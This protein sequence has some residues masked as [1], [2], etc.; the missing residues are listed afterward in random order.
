MADNRENIEIRLI[1][2]ADLKGFQ[3]TTR[4]LGAVDRATEQSIAKQKQLQQEIARTARELRTSL[5]NPSVNPSSTLAS[6][7]VPTRQSSAELRR[8]EREA[9]LRTERSMALEDAELTRR[10]NQ[11]NQFF[12]DAQR[13]RSATQ[14][15]IDAGQL[16]GMEPLSKLQLL[17]AAGTVAGTAAKGFSE[18]AKQQQATQGLAAAMAQHGVLSD[19]F[20]TRLQKLAETQREGTGTKKAQWLEALSDL[21]ASGGDASNID[22]LTKGV[23]DLAGIMN[24]NIPHA[25]L[26][27][28]KAMQGNFDTL[29]EWGIIVPEAATQ[30]QKLDSALQQMAEKGAN[31]LRARAESL[32]GQWTT[33]KESTN[34]LLAAFAGTFANSELL[35]G[36]LSGLSTIIQKAA[37]WIGRTDPPLAQMNVRLLASSRALTDAQ[38][39]AAAASREFNSIASTADRAAQALNR[40]R[41]AADS[42]RSAQDQLGDAE[43]QLQ[44]AQI[45]AAEHSGRLSPQAAN[46]ARAG[47]RRSSQVSQFGRAQAGDTETISANERRLNQLG[48]QRGLL[49]SEHADLTGRV[50]TFQ[51]A[52]AA[53]AEAADDARVFAAAQRR[54][55][56]ARSRPTIESI[57]ASG[58]QVSVMGPAFSTEEVRRREREVSE[59]QSRAQAS[60]ARAGQFSITDEQGR[61][62][63]EQLA[64]NTTALTELRT[65]IQNET[66]GLQDSISNAR[67]SR[68]T[69]GLRFGIDQTRE[70]V[71]LRDQLGNSPVAGNV[72]AIRNGAGDEQTNLVQQLRTAIQ[73]RQDVTMAGFTDLV[74]AINQDI[75]NIQA[76]LRQL[77]TRR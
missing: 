10:N 3:D 70:N 5:G 69:R 46:L 26:A 40:Q 13:Q 61:Q 57:A 73:L 62:L 50:Q 71:E 43:L 12:A 77:N 19:E 36:S 8:L 67:L 55:A 21:V 35:K 44:L 49:E 25:S 39:S 72:S 75:R 32:S 59:A 16:G 27:L 20:L 30:A 33:L 45:D 47:A 28:Q 1:G 17:A 52:H 31:Q 11:R 64:Q 42:V 14:G 22:K 2:T 54:L 56:E 53:R 60:G 15:A 37:E 29:R 68:D 63:Q 6:P 4:G 18:L 76:Q 38:N 48:T 7:F 65:V 24:G 58:G 34:N 23:E 51:Q 41:Q 66:P 74:Q 9:G